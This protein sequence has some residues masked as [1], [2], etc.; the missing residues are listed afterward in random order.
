MEDSIDRIFPK[1]DETYGRGGLKYRLL[2]LETLKKSLGSIWDRAGC[3]TKYGVTEIKDIDLKF[4]D[5]IPGTIGKLLQDNQ[6][7]IVTDYE[8]YLEHFDEIRPFGKVLE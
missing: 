4:D 6:S 7:Y 1:G 5:Y 8:L 2:D 3:L